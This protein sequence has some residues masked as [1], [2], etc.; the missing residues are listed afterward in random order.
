VN[1]RSRLD[2]DFQRHTYLIKSP[3][4]EVKS[5][6]PQLYT[7]QDSLFWLL[8]NSTQITLEE[9]YI[10]RPDLLSFDQYGT[11]QLWYVLLFVNNYRCFEDFIGPKV[12]VPSY[13]S[14]VELVRLQEPDG[15]IETTIKVDR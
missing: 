11:E 1:S 5:K 9:K 8:Y 7:L 3:T 2:E 10:T 6:G 4:L 13:D 15:T 14:I 12:Y